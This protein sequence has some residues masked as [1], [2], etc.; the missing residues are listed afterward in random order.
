VHSAQIAFPGGKFEQEDVDFA[1]TALR[2]TFEEVGV[3]P[4]K[5]E[6]IK[7]FTQ[8]YIPPSNFMVYPYLGICQNE[9]AFRLDPKEVAGIIELPLAAFLTDR[10]LVVTQME[11]SNANS[12]E[13]PAFQ[14]EN[15]TVWG[16]TAMMLSELKDVLV[17]V[18]N[19]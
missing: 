8:V 15:H 7:P 16:A 19:S 4:D 14:I 17:G 11:T 18:V 2:E 12:I 3:H 5:I 13:I 9:I 10:L 6:I 1:A